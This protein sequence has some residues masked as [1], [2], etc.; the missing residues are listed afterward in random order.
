[1]FIFDQKIIIFIF[2]LLHIVGIIEIG[3]KITENVINN[4]TQN[5]RNSFVLKKIIINFR[6]F[7]NMF[8][9]LTQMHVHFV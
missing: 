6:I 1:M 2:L 3:V 8:A 7:V 9:F 4:I 5:I